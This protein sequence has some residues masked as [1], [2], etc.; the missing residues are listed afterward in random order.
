MEIVKI[1]LINSIDRLITPNKLLGVANKLLR[2]APATLGPPPGLMEGPGTRLDPENHP[3]MLPNRVEIAKIV[4]IN[5]VDRL[6][7]LNKLLGADNNLLGPTPGGLGTRAGPLAADLTSENAS[8]WS[9]TGW[10]SSK[11][12]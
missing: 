12:S 1:V 4:L 6:I 11:S 7:T 8:K 3:K 2:P 9:K 10:K 5:G